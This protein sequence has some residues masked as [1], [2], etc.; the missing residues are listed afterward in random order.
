MLTP[1]EEEYLKALAAQRL[2]QK[3]LNKKRKEKEQ[4]ISDAIA[5]VNSLYDSEIKTLEDAVGNA[6]R[7][8]ESIDPDTV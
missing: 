3:K 4:A 2:A 5:S 6:D 1:K 7:T 8:V